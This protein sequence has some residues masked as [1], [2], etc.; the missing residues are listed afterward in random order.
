LKIS[1]L[2]ATASSA[3]LATGLLSG[4]TGADSVSGADPEKLV[5]AGISFGSDVQT[6]D[7]YKLLIELLSHE[8]GMEIEFYETSSYGAIVESMVSGQVHI[9]QLNQLGYVLATNNVPNLE[10]VGV[11][12]ASATAPLTA[13]GYGIKRSDNLEVNS[14]ED[15]RG[16]KV[17]FP[18]PLSTT[19]YLTPAKALFDLG[20]DPSPTSSE[21]IDPVFVG[22][23]LEVGFA[24]QRGDCEVGFLNDLTFSTLLPE[25]GK[26]AAGE[27]EAFWTSP[28][29]PNPPL[30]VSGEISEEL[31]A[32]IREVVLT[33]GNRTALV[34]GGY[35]TD[36]AS[37]T[38]IASNRWGW[39]EE[40]DAAFAGIR[41]TCLVLNIKECN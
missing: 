38:L 25:T 33:K 39:R 41:E 11:T 16:K 19:G 3:F 10:L 14:L 18:D 32:K 23:F 13:F 28:S 36:E 30:V 34:A 2:I 24:V 15:I 29:V 5:F 9:A 40:T 4:C 8:L 35:C 37:C 12:S 7:S 21:D 1:K 27:L 20:I 22:G 26:I 6:Y 31:R 17:C